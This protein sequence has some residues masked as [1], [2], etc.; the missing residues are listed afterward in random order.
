MPGNTVDSSFNGLSSMESRSDECPGTPRV[1]SPS[2]AT[3]QL[4]L[5]SLRRGEVW[6]WSPWPPRSRD[7]LVFGAILMSALVT[8]VRPVSAF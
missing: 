3:R 5:L 2:Y 4:R 6:L 1:P 8:A 7:G